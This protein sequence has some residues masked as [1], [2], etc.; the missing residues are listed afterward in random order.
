MHGSRWVATMHAWYSVQCADGSGVAHGA[1]GFVMMAPSRTCAGVCLTH[2]L[3]VLVAWR[4]G[5]LVQWHVMPLLEVSNSMCWHMCRT[6]HTV[7]WQSVHQS[8]T[9]VYV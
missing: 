7:D 4:P 5:T 2:N 3:G 9:A 1:W 6:P 8:S